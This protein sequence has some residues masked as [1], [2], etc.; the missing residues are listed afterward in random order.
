MRGEVWTLQ[1]N[2]YAGKARPVVIIQAE[3]EHSFGSVVIC[4]FTSYESNHISTRVSP[5]KKLCLLSIQIR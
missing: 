4:L 5:L 2:A 3:L 1:D